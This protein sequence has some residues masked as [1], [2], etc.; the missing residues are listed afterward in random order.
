MR[1]FVRA[2]TLLAVLLLCLDAYLLY[3]FYKEDPALPVTKAANAVS[4]VASRDDVAAGTRAEDRPGYADQVGRI[5]AGAV[6]AFLDSNDRLLRY[7]KLVA[8]DVEALEA[9]HAA[10]EEY[11][12][13]ASGLDP[14]KKREDQHEAFEFALGDLH[15]A[16]ELAHRLAADP[17]SATQSDFDAYALHVDRAGEHLRRSNKALDRGFETIEGARMPTVG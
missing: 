13:R 10:L 11:R 5:Q 14:P 2:T 12:R 8:D 6:G 4:Q 3:G 15:Y 16:A 7:D 1:I 17:V 9:N